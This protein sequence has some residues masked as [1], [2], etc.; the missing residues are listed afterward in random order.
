MDDMLEALMGA[1]AEGRGEGGG[2]V[3]TREGGSTLQKSS[4]DSQTRLLLHGRDGHTRAG[5][6][7]QE[8]RRARTN[9]TLELWLERRYGRLSKHVWDPRWA[10]VHD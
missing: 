10:K 9:A 6:R 3:G 4:C 7:E 2:G 1:R 5:G 8:E